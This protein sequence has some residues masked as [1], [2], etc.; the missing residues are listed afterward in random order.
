ML[1]YAL[2][3]VHEIKFI[4]KSNKCEV[5]IKQIAKEFAQLFNKEYDEK[6]WELFGQKELTPIFLGY[7]RLD[8][9]LDITGIRVLIEYICDDD[10]ADREGIKIDDCAAGNLLVHFIENSS[11][12]L[13]LAA[14]I[15]A[16]YELKVYYSYLSW[17]SNCIRNK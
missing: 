14:Y 12:I 4:S 17:K 15:N 9:T 2:K 6:Y 3:N 5:E 13:K 16:K 10:A 1:L 7:A 11:D 8:E